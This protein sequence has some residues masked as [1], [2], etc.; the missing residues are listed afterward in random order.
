MTKGSGAKGTSD[1]LGGASSLP[2]SGFSPAAPD[3]G[4]GSG[5]LTPQ[6]LEWLANEASLRYRKV[7]FAFSELSSWPEVEEELRR[8]FQ[9]LNLAVSDGGRL[10]ETIGAL[11][12]SLQARDGHDEARNRNQ[13]AENPLSLRDYLMVLLTASPLQDVIPGAGTDAELGA[14]RE[15]VIGAVSRGFVAAVRRIGETAEPIEAELLPFRQAVLQLTRTDLRRLGQPRAGEQSSRKHTEHLTSP[16]DLRDAR[17]VEQTRR[18]EEG[19]G[20]NAI[21]EVAPGPKTLPGQSPPFSGPGL[22]LPSHGSP[23][24]IEGEIEHRFREYAEAHPD[25]ARDLASRLTKIAEASGGLSRERTLG[26]REAARRI[27]KARGIDLHSTQL[28]R[29]FRDPRIEIGAQGP[30]GKPRFSEYECANFIPPD[31]PLGRP[32][33]NPGTPS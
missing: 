3:L 25:L 17:V 11:R 28:L 16:G 13:R 5:K 1:A 14:R 22:H 23:Q 33:K 20:A 30:E 18:A 31:R 32:K 29:Y 9:E 10:A 8:T 27:S 12:G 26:L 21:G 15:A 6:H 4:P 2:G 24:A 7:I 19:S